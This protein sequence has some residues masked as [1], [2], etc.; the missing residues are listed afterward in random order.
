MRNPTER[1]TPMKFE[2]APARPTTDE[3]E[4]LEAKH[5]S[6]LDEHYGPLWG[7]DDEVAIEKITTALAAAYDK[8]GIEE[9]DRIAGI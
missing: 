1:T 3:I 2:V 7:E 8:A 6:Y 9:F 5:E 4:E